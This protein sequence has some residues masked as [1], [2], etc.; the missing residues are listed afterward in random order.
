MFGL[1]RFK[2]TQLG[3]RVGAI[4]ED[5][6]NIA[7]MVVFSRHGVPAVKAIGKALLTLGSEVQ[8]DY[9]KTTIGRWVKEILGR[10]GWTPWKSARVTPGNLFS[11]GMVYKESKK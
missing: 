9:V 4:V 6:Q 11:R 7:E 1:D 5:K 8:D 3:R 2:E 10:R